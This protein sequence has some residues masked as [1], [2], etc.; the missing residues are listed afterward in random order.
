MKKDYYEILGVKKESSLEDIKKAYR[1]LALSHHPDRVPAEK[2]KGAEEKFKEISEAYAVLS[3]PQ[4]RSMYDQH[5]HQGIDQQYTYEDIFKGA[6]FNSIFEGLREFGFGSSRGSS[7]FD[8]IFGD[9]GGESAGSHRTRR[10]RRGRDI[11]YEVELTLEEA[12]RGVAKTIKVPRHDLCE[13]CQGTGAKPGSKA[14]TCSACRG[15]GQ[16]VMSNGF[17]RMAQTCSQCGGQGKVI[18]EFCPKCQG[19]GTVRV[20][21]N[22]EVKFPAGVDNTSQLRVRGEG[23]AG[24]Q[25]RG[26]LYIDVHIKAHST[27]ERD[28]DNVFM[29]LP[30]SFVKVALGSEVSVP[31]LNGSVSMKIPAGTQSGKVFRLKGKGMPSLQSSTPGDQYVKVMIQVPEHLTSEQKNLLEQYARISGEDVGVQDSFTD[32]LKKVFK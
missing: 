26:D 30:I 11:Q 16:I 21:R 12:Y 4:K 24:T 6:D 22:I 27:F 20:T 13:D 15:Q 7:I 3:D 9:L 10:A 17:F 14:K 5:G 1:S 25:G 23:E 28:A 18:A 31:T 8:Q 32:K 19:K 29:E 2:K